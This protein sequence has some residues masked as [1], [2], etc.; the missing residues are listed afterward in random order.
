[1]IHPNTRKSTTRLARVAAFV[2]AAAALALAFAAA[3]TRAD[4]QSR[5]LLNRLVQSSGN[6]DAATRALDQARSMIDM[7]R[8][9]QAASAFDKFISQYPSDKSVDAALYWL[10][11][12]YNKQ[13][14]FQGAY[15]A[16]A[17]LLQNYPRSSWA[18]DGKVLSVEVMS[19][20]N[21]NYRPDVDETNGDEE[22]SIIAPR[23]LCE[24]DR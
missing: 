7:Q 24:N 22:L 11:Y 16:L 6:S 18:N 23:T 10:A 13:N 21:P 4:A 9:A 20:L 2:F 17:R 8:W 1:M 15:D 3:P 5:E 12:A 19:K 14:N